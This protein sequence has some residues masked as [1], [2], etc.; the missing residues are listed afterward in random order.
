MLFPRIISAAAACRLRAHL[1][2]GGLAAYPTESGYG[3]GCLPQHRPALQ[4]LIRLK[5][6]PQHKGLIVVGNNLRQL[7]PL[8]ADLPAQQRRLAQDTWPAAVTLLLPAASGT[9]AI[10]RGRGRGKLAVRVPAHAG[11]RRLCAVLG[12]PLVSTSCNRSGRRP[13]RHAREV[14]RCFGRQVFVVPGRCGGAKR[15]SRIVDAQ[16]GQ[17]LR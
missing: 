12:T 4:R 1:R 3:L 17:R 11:A 8:L 2:R 14:R 10:L 6:R 7:Q 13:L 15:P 16:T 5:K 9:P